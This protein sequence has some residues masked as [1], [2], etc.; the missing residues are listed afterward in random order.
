MIPGDIAFIFG[1]LV[2]FIIG[3]LIG[4]SLH[5]LDCKGTLYI[6]HTPDKDKYNFE[7]D[8]LDLLEANGYVTLRIKVEN[9]EEENRHEV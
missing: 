2:F 3:L 7:I 5:K 1:L 8:N 9:E 4:S 6:A